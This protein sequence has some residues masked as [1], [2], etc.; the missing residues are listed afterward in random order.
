MQLYHACDTFHDGE[1]DKDIYYIN[2]NGVSVSLANIFS[3]YTI[4]CLMHML[5]FRL[6]LTTVKIY[7]WAGPL[8]SNFTP[9]GNKNE[10]INMKT[11]KLDFINAR[12]YII[13]LN[14]M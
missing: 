11:L 13:G 4:I 2:Q 12:S 3:I 8:Y 1:V 6:L 9:S 14:G 5:H 10:K 7:T